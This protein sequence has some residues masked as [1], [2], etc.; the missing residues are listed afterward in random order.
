MKKFAALLNIGGYKAD[1]LLDFFYG[2]EGLLGAKIVGC[3]E[4][5]APEELID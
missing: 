1:S 5:L 2:L 4:E 3:D